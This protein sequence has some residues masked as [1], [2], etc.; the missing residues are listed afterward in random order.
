MIYCAAGPCSDGEGRAGGG[1]AADRQPAA[2][3]GCRRVDRALGSSTAERGWVS[4]SGS[5]EQVARNNGPRAESSSCRRCGRHSGSIWA[6]RFQCLPHAMPQHA[7]ERRQCWPNDTSMGA[8]DQ[9]GLHAPGRVWW[10]GE[11][12]KEFQYVRWWAWVKELRWVTKEERR[13]MRETVDT[14]QAVLGCART[15]CSLVG[16]QPTEG[17]RCLCSVCQGLSRVSSQSG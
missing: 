6:Q 11:P 17:M 5:G 13:S 9:P 16:L 2:I 10:S 4:T 3:G 12:C 14:S 8:L 1:L 15:A 7:T